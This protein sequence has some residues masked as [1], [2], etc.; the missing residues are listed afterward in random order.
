[1]AE[2]K[3]EENMQRRARRIARG[4]G[5]TALAAGLLLGSDGSADNDSCREWRQDH[6]SWKTET[7]RRYLR[8]APQPEVDAA[9]F[10][11]LQR[12]A[13]LT[14]CEVSVRNGRDDLVGWRLVGRNPEE[15]GTVVVESV[16]E[17]AGFDLGLESIF[18]APPERVAKTISRRRARYGRGV[19]PR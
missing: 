16:L 14:S 3:G 12:E 8:G 19:G 7:L 11:V 10:E 2:P 5:G 6:F 13:Y 9:V 17:R 4:I 1:M 18:S 15:Y